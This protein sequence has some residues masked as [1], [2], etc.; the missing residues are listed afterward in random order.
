[1][2]LF[3]YKTIYELRIKQAYDYIGVF[4]YASRVAK[5]IFIYYEFSRPFTVESIVIITINIYF[6]ARLPWLS[7]FT[8]VLRYSRR[9]TAMRRTVRFIHIHWD[10]DIQTDEV[11]SSN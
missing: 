9:T 7:N 3:V 8:R 1:M 4:D 6:F 5:N 11:Q 2:D 10:L